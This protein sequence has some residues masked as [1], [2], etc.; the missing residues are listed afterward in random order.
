MIEELLRQPHTRCSTSELQALRESLKGIDYTTRDVE[1]LVARSSKTSAHEGAERTP[2]TKHRLQLLGMMAAY[3]FE[4]E[5]EV[6]IRDVHY[7][8]FGTKSFN[9]IDQEMK[10]PNALSYSIDAEIEGC[11]F[12]GD[13]VGE[14]AKDAVVRDSEF[15]GTDVLRNSRRVTLA[16]VNAMGRNFCTYSRHLTAE[17][18]VVE[19]GHALSHMYD[20]KIIADELS[21]CR[22]LCSSRHLLGYIDYAKCIVNPASG[23]L[24][25][26]RL[27]H[28]EF[29]PGKFNPKH[30][31]IFVVEYEGSEG[32]HHE[33][34]KIY[35]APEMGENEPPLIRI[36]E[37]DIRGEW[38]PENL[39]E[40][41][42]E[43]CRRYEVQMPGCLQEA[44]KSG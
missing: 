13:Y 35:P 3:M 36:R 29:N 6:P 26:R 24:V 14:R 25:I 11:Q 28:A 1:N 20:S 40:R 44:L 21:A 18:G 32:P 37:S 34:K 2:E 41:L 22:A 19:G 16:D 4:Q 12:S 17:L 33:G 7:F 5:L 43:I 30:M 9:L 23:V 10:A 31:K 15:F 42:A 27:V 38:T 8:G 39:P